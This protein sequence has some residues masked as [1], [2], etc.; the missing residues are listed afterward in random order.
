V[1]ASVDEADIGRVEPGKRAVFTVPAFPQETFAGTVNQVRND[2]K[3]EQNVVT[4]T[5][6]LDV[7]NSSL[8]LR[9]GMTAT[10]TIMVEEVNDAVL[11]PEGALRFKPPAVGREHQSRPSAAAPGTKPG[12]PKTEAT[13]WKFLPDRNIAPVKV[14]LGLQ[15][16]EKVQIVSEELKPG[17]RVVVQAVSKKDPQKHLQGLRF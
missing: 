6:V 12:L 2:P 4:Y 8:K 5:V 10:V 11:I 1:H 14:R 7:D 9:P 16:N 13:A 3:I 17:D 15:G